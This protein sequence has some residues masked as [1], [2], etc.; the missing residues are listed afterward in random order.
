VEPLKSQVR[1]R[2]QIPLS[3]WIPMSLEEADKRGWDRFDII[4]ITGDAYVDHPSFGTA[5]IARV[6]ENAGYRVGI[7]S[8]PNWQDD[9]RDFRKLGKPALFFGVTAGNMDS[10]VNHY[11]AFRRLRSDDAYTAGGKSGFRPDYA[12]VVYSCILKELYPEIPVVLGGI[13]ASMRRLVH[14][15]YWSDSLKPSILE[16]SGADLLI[17][18]MGEKSIIE[19]A[20]LYNSGFQSEK[21]A[22]IRQIAYMATNETGIEEIW[23][24]TTHLPPYEECKASREVFAEAFRLAEIS[25]NRM[26]PECL[27]Q[28]TGN[29]FLVQNPS[30]SASSVQELDQIYSLPFTRLPHPRYKKRGVVPAWT[31]IRDSVNIHRG[32]FGGCSFCTISV[33]QGKFISS[34]SES[35]ILEELKKIAETE[36]FSGIV[37]DLGGPSANMYRMGGMKKDICEKC[38][39]PSCLWP[40][41]CRNLRFD[42]GPLI[43][44][45]QKALKIKG[46]KKVFIG[47][48]IRY[49]MLTGQLP[50][51]S[52][53]YRLNEYTRTVVKNH[54][55]GRLK[56]APEHTDPKVLS[57]VRKP[58]FGSYLSFRQEFKKINEESGL[59]Q[60]LI[61]YLIASLPGCGI[62]EMGEMAAELSLINTRP[63]QVQ[64]FTPTPMTLASVMF[65]SGINPYTKERVYIGASD[66]ERKDQRM[67]LFYYKEEHKSRIISELKKA[68]HSELILKIYRRQ[69]TKSEKV[70]VGHLQNERKKRKGVTRRR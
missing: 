68:G 13:E 6:L 16:I 44:L 40:K 1:Q 34:R 33:H 2:D 22:G 60:Q 57:L 31:M 51:I 29:R 25:S 70:A 47:S 4:L 67:F 7:I 66:A 62:K 56:V 36:G 8:Q 63:E 9:L 23:G 39:R 65:Y 32:C 48:G 41:I 27:I 69:P 49:D 11:T 61:P 12:T 42:H 55:S 21:L 45:Y 52:G 15:D 53:R 14:Y 37:T 20:D 35:S 38:I 24:K 46:I 58:A 5:V 50:E 28:P 43:E 18:G 17:Y 19:V 30:W 3:S 26:S 10:M 59:R 54:V 64:D